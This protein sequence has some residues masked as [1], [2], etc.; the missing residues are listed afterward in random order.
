ML[1]SAGIT[2]SKL[3]FAFFGFPVH[4]EDD[5]TT[6]LD[7]LPATALGS[8][9][10]RCGN[11]M[12]C[13][14]AGSLGG[15]DGINVVAG[16]GSISYGEYQAATARCGGWGELFSDEGSAF[17][18]ARSGF[19]L[20]SRMSDGRAPKGPLYDLFREKLDDRPDLELTAWVLAE[21]AL[22]RSKIAALA[23][24]VHAAAARGDPQ[25]KQIFIFAAQELADLVMAT[26]RTLGVPV[27]ITLPVSYSG[28]V[29]GIGT[30]VTDPFQA[31]LTTSGAKY[32]LTVPRFSPV[33]GAALYAAKLAK[34]PLSIAA[35][36][37]LQRHNSAHAT[38][39]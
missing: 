8:T 31:A 18:I 23:K 10:F 33:I 25:A 5:Q 20:F 21:L 26:R 16:T 12:V 15:A 34:L 11:D 37:N 29:F 6:V 36:Q 13:G 38:A 35:Q 2:A 39:D 17:W 24:L 1:K 22:G 19:T 4:G 7:A 27:D 3:N 30:M 14:W 28:G 32:A 9:P